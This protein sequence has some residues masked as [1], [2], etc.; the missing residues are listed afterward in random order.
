MMFINK[1]AFPSPMGI[2]VT[3]LNQWSDA[4]SFMLT[5]G[6]L[7]APVS[8]LVVN[9]S[10]LEE[11][12][13]TSGLS[14]AESEVSYDAWVV[15]CATYGS[16]YFWMCDDT[17]FEHALCPLGHTPAGEEDMHDCSA[18]PAGR[19]AY[20]IDAQ[21][22]AN[23]DD[24]PCA[25]SCAARLLQCTDCPRASLFLALVTRLA[26]SVPQA[27][28]LRRARSSARLVLAVVP[29]TK[30][31]VHRCATSA[32]PGALP[33]RMALQSARYVARASIKTRQRQWRARLA[34]QA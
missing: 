25:P 18:C 9:N 24:K 14:S 23:G 22:D 7:A 12:L 27:H 29:L 13:R 16:D 21:V 8:D 33:A 32:R 4:Y 20:N 3:E 15:F 30:A 1:L 11:A 2:G 17:T 6:D 34:P 31:V 28:S 10:S 5:V 26:S 19:Y